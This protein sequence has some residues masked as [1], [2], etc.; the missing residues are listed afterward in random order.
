MTVSSDLSRASYVA[1]TGPFVFPV[2]FYFLDAAHIRVVRRTS[3]GAETVL[4][5]GTQYDVA[6][7]GDLAGGSVTIKAG[8]EPDATDRIVIVRNVPITQETDYVENDAFTAETHERALDKLTMIN[9]Q[10]TEELGR[11]LKLPISA[12]ASDIDF[13]EPVGGAL[14]KWN[15]GGTALETAQLASLG[16]SLDVLVSEPAEGDFL[17]WNGT[18]FVNEQPA[19]DHLEDIDLATDAPSEGDL[20]QYDGAKFVPVNASEAGL[21]SQGLHAV[22][23][24]AAAWRPQL[25]DGCA[26]LDEVETSTNKVMISCLAFDPVADEHAQASFRLPPSIDG[27]AGISGFIEWM[28]APGGS[29]RNVHWN[30]QCQAQGD[31]DDPDGAW[32]TP[33][34]AHD[35]DGSPA[36]GERRVVAFSGMIAAGSPATGDT[37]L[38]RL[39]RKATDEGDTCDADARLLGVMLFLTVSGADDS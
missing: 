10:Q 5:A 28:E 1:N 30:I 17:A 18:H 39:L 24:P 19:L 35:D 31:G 7:A 33:V 14:I 4:T 37:L 21:L 22:Y 3:A 38:L 34:T 12:S 32:G 27:T 26:S 23:L 11:A 25:T 13:P 16:G 8:H 20:F 2:P 9:Q 29:A 15:S 6:G 36:G